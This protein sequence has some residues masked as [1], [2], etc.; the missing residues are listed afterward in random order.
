MSESVKNYF[1]GK[2]NTS[3]RGTKSS[4]GTREQAPEK[5]K[6]DGLKIRLHTSNEKRTSLNPIDNNKNNLIPEVCE[7]NSFGLLVNPL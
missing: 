3:L 5:L 2:F 6:E 4:Q 1:D 7:I